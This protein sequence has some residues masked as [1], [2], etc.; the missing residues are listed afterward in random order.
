MLV[1]LLGTV[2]T[3]F[4][5][6]PIDAIWLTLWNNAG[7]LFTALS[8]IRSQA[9]GTALG[10]LPPGTLSALTIAVGGVF[11]L[12]LLD[13]FADRLW[14]RLTGQEPPNDDQ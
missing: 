4:Q 13:K 6:G 1:G 3:L 12:S 14:A 10:F 7:T 8:V 5:A 11:V 9:D 2:A